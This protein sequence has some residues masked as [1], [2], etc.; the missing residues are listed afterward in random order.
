MDKIRRHSEYLL[1]IATSEYQF[2][3]I[4]PSLL[5]ASVVLTAFSGLVQ[6]IRKPSLVSVLSRLIGRPEKEINFVKSA[7]ERL[8]EGYRE[9]KSESSKPLVDNVAFNHVVVV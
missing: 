8:I 2:L 3:S 1:I 9:Y 5:A 4:S 7:I 6:H